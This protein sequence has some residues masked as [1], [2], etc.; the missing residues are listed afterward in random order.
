MSLAWPRLWL[1]HL[2]ECGSEKSIS[3][4]I[5]KSLA[6]VSIAQSRWMKDPGFTG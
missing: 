5:K 1:M 4:K 2:P 6:I 3:N